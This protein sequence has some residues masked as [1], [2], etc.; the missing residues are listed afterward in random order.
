MFRI[1]LCLPDATQRRVVRA[2]CT[3]YFTRRIETLQ[4]ASFSP[5]SAPRDADL[6]FLSAAGPRPNG[7]DVAARLRRENSRASI[8]FIASGPEYAMEAFRVS[9]LQYLIPPVPPARMFETLDRVMTRRR[10]PA[11]AVPT[12]PGLQQLPF[13]EIEY[14]ECTDHILHFHMANGQTLRS[15]TLRISLSKALEPLMA[16]SRFYQAH[17]SYVIN[18]DMVTLLADGEFRMRS[19][20]AVPVPQGR[21]AEAEARYRAAMR[22]SPYPVP[23]REELG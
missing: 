3:E 18:L 13:S 22:P 2:L 16:D 15:T 4:I 10:G 9:A 20:A 1:A 12:R 17:R 8:I 11:L 23:L 14:V 19:G 21:A 5:D 7:M 6:I